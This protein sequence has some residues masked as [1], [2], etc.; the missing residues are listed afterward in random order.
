[1]KRMKPKCKICGEMFS[2]RR[3]RVG[4]KVCLECGEEQAQQVRHCIAPLHKS[5]YV[6]ITNR[7]D[8]AGLNNKGGLVK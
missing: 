3:A 1:M 4:Y 2:V 8:L 7:Q 5:N 6:V